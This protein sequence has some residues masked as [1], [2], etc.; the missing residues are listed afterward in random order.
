MHQLIYVLPS[1]F[2]SCIQLEPLLQ[3]KKLRVILARPHISVVKL[4]DPRQCD[5][6]AIL[7][8]PSKALSEHYLG[9]KRCSTNAP[10]L[11]FITTIQPLGA[12][13]PQACVYLHFLFTAVYTQQVHLSVCQSLL[14]VRWPFAVK[15]SKHPR[16][17]E[18]QQVGSP[19]RQR[20][21]FF[22]DGFLRDSTSWTH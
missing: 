8:P 11:S 5:S 1:I 17:R 15:D 12:Q 13:P 19:E 9:L 21:A 2:A 10:S 4:G 22:V 7:L 3:M 14:L 6:R 18:G 16:R 20:R